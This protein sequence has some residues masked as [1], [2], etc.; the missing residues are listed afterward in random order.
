MD[1]LD[2]ETFGPLVD[3]QPSSLVRLASK[4]A[5]RHLRTSTTA[6]QLTA[7]IGG[8]YNIAH[9][10]EIGNGKLVIRVPV[11][12]WGT[13]LTP[14]AAR[15]MESQVT[16]MR[17]IRS[18]TTLPVPE[19]YAFDATIDNEIGAPYICMSFLPGVPVSEVW[20]HDMAPAPRD[21]LRLRILGSLAHQ[22]AQ[23]HGLVFDK[24]GSIFMD[25]SDLVTVGPLF[26]WLEAEDGCLHVTESG[27][28]DSTAGFLGA[29]LA[30]TFDQSVWDRAEAKVLDV[31][32][33]CIPRLDSAPGFVICP[34]DFDSQNVLVDGEGTVTGI[35]DWDLAHTMPRF[36]GF[37]RY[38][39]WITRDWDPLMYGWPK[40]A[41]S[42][43]SPATLAR[44]REFYNWEMGKALQQNED[45]KFTKKSHIAEAMWIAALSS[46]NRL[47]I[48]RKFVQVALGEDI[49]ALDVLY[50]VGAGG[51]GD[52]AWNALETKLRHWIDR[53]C[54]GA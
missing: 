18:R 3:I 14:S 37:S 22:M 8:S 42:E 29:H 24:M 4:I 47:E 53:T 11:T 27:P 44:Y 17:L 16:T 52:E 6:G 50:A 51:Y 1:E 54:G 34:P 5:A 26:D 23:L 15:A 36:L 48:C 35:I 19:V 38:P 31:I 30:P 2:R 25:G 41:D 7:R 49:K 20:F 40:M 32:L 12:G 46:R 43:D 28:F 10:V 33:D 45:W 39:G 9:V 21:A 13:A